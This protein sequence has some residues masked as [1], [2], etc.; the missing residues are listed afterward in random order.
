MS[1]SRRSPRPLGVLARADALRDIQCSEQLRIARAAKALA[2]DYESSAELMILLKSEHRAENRHGILYALSWHQLKELWP[3]AVQI[4]SNTD[5]P[6]IVRGQAAEA[7]SYL[8]LEFEV[9]SRD[10]TDAVEAL[11]RATKDPSSEV[12]YCAA[13]ALGC[14]GDPGL[15]PVLES[16]LRDTTQVPG[17]V[18]TVGDEAARAIE[19]V[20]RMAERRTR[21]SSK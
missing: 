9:G 18:G 17:W 3:I 11:I 15:V 4:V 19:W 20:G 6:A 12:R 14:S 13:N 16:L 21:M 10:F 2:G 1:N 5:E 7:I 8:F